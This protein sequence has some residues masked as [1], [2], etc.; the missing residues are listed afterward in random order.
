M[1]FVTLHIGLGTF[2]GIQTEDVRDFDIH[3]EQAEVP[4]SIFFEIAAYRQ[5]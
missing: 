3:S 4:L 5:S 1:R 2:A